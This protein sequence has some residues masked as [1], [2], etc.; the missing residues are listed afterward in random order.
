M[1]SLLHADTPVRKAAAVPPKP[2][3]AP[4]APV[5][6]ENA[7]AEFEPEFEIVMGRRQIA[8]VALLVVVSMAVFSGVSYLVGRSLGPRPVAPPVQAAVQPAPAPPPVAAPAPAPAPV[9]P[10]PE[11]QPVAAPVAQASTALLFADP[12]QGAVYIQVGAV[13]KGVAAVWAE[14]LRTHGLDAFVGPGPNDKIFRV[15]VGPLPNPD[16]YT[17]AKQILDSIGLNTFGKRYQQ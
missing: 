3:P 5:A 4:P 11:P 7:P 12:V 17:H 14:G 15:L 8:S 1:I 9:V 2:A 13:E 16:S 10:P 6:D